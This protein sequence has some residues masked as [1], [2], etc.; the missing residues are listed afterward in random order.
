[1]ARIRSIKP[2]FCTSEDIACLTI[3]CRLHFVML[4]T[5]AD[6]QGRG[7]DNGRLLK[8]ALWPLDDEVTTEVIEGWQIELWRAGR[9]TRYSLDGKVYFEITNF[10]EHQHPNRPQ[11]SR[12]PAQTDPGVI[13]HEQ[14]SECSVSDHGALTPVV[15]GRGGEGRGGS[16]CKTPD[17]GPTLPDAPADAPPKATPKLNR[18][19]RE[20]I[21]TKVA[22]VLID[23]DGSRQRASTKTDPG[24]YL[25][26]VR[27]GKVADY[28]D[29]VHALLVKDP[30]LTPEQ[31]AD[32]LE[33]P[34]PPPPPPPA[35]YEPEG[36][37]HG[38]PMPA[39]LRSVRANLR[40]DGAA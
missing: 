8:G 33:P 40:R 27:A 38:V 20:A 28:R 19:Q 32:E 4:W 7:I 29:A 24:S 11:A 22:N 14:L 10:G 9:I 18:Q 15:E 25:G 2:G 26:S 21:L 13:V 34:P 3:P 35:E 37:G 30:A 36:I 39:S 6:D 16:A 1:M 12:L 23:R 17:T 31:I 5:Y